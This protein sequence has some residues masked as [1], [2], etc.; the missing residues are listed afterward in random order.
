MAL[1]EL[2]EVELDSVCGGGKKGGYELTV[3]KIRQNQDNYTK[4][5]FSKGVDASN[6]QV[7]QIGE[8]G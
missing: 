2:T 3:V 6:N 4:V 5:V 7:V 1:Y 8:I